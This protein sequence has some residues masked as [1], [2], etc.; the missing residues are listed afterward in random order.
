MGCVYRTRIV[1]PFASWQE[2]WWGI[3]DDAAFVTAALHIAA[4][5]RILLQFHGS[6]KSERTFSGI[7]FVYSDA[8]DILSNKHMNAALRVW[9]E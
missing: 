3:V 8:K 6:I 2:L 4:L 1:N 5:L 7:N 9:Y